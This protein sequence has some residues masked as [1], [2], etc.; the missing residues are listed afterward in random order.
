MRIWERQGT[1]LMCLYITYFGFG[2]KIVGVD[3]VR[4]GQDTSLYAVLTSFSQLCESRPKVLTDMWLIGSCFGTI[5]GT[6]LLCL[7]QLYQTRFVR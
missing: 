7:G 2:A 4:R 1:V 3:V 5:N 6:R